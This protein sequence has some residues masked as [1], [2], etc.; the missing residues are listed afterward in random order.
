MT[1]I[2]QQNEAVARVVLEKNAGTGLPPAEQAALNK[3]QTAYKKQSFPE[4]IDVMK[5]AMEA[6]DNAPVNRGN[7]E[8][9]RKG[10]YAGTDIDPTTGGAALNAEQQGRHDR[11]EKA[12]G[13]AADLLDKGFDNLS[14]PDQHMVYAAV[15]GRL[16]QWP[17][18]Q[19][20]LLGMNAREKYDTVRNLM[21]R[22]E[23]KQKLKDVLDKGVDA[24]P[25]GEE[26]KKLQKDVTD[27]ERGMQAADTEYKVKFQEYMAAGAKAQAFDAFVSPGDKFDLLDKLTKQEPKLI[28]DKAKAQADLDAV[29]AEIDTL[30]TLLATSART[31]PEYKATHAELLTKAPA[32]AD[33]KR[34]LSTAD[35]KLE[36]KRQL[37]AEKT[38]AKTDT[39]T[40]EAETVKAYQKFED[41][42]RDHLSAKATLELA[43]IKMGSAEEQRAMAA[44]KAVSEAA[45][46]FILAE[47]ENAEKARQDMLTTMDAEAKTEAD[48]KIKKELEMRYVTITNNYDKSAVKPN[49]ESTRVD[50][51]NILRN[52][53]DVFVEQFLFDAG[54]SGDEIKEKMAREGEALKT[55]LI[56]EVLA[57]RV[58]TGR[59]T[60]DEAQVIFQS[61]WGAE[62]VKAAA[63]KKTALTDEIK[64]LTASGA[65]DGGALDDINKLLSGAGKSVDKKMIGK[66]F[67]LAA[68][69]MILFSVGSPILAA[70]ALASYAASGAMKG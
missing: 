61:E 25:L 63:A 27:K 60:N 8:A 51:E 37:E 42:Q 23:F 68:L 31:S 64:K 2:L 57:R 16:Q 67:G 47:A 41:A 17:E 6:A 24:G 33:A 1:D 4:A 11:E 55:K 26:F 14:N 46:L 35:A 65:I 56:G 62:A 53:P 66:G 3:L 50:Y 32:Q 40:L 39:V 18:A 34:R 52:G 7:L 22:P 10:A 36:Q 5:S 19:A 44:E 12:E 29:E 21:S 15:M 49:K 13:R 59:I 28:A 20:L 30:K 69:L 48:K 45:K 9:A 54:L 70:G 58:Q 43:K 38:K